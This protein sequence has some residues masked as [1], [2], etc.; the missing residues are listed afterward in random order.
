MRTWSKSTSR[1]E[2]A[3]RSTISV[4]PLE[5]VSGPVPG[6]LSTFLR[7]G[8]TGGL[9]GFLGSSEDFLVFRNRD[10]V[11]Q[12]LDG[13]CPSTAAWTMGVIYSSALTLKR[14]SRETFGL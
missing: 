11:G 5:T 14:S 9:F 8:L 13:Y 2:G 4:M 6:S 1:A 3:I 10:I 7:P 12:N